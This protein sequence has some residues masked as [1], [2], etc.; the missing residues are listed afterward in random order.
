MANDLVVAV[1]ANIQQLERQMKAAAQVSEK[2]AADIENRFRKV[3]PSIS[4]SALTGAL[5]GFAAAFTVD[6]IIRGLADANAELV[7]VGETA[8]RV[9]LDLQRF[10]E[11]QFAGR[12]NGL[13]GK[14]F[15]TGLE[16][17]AEKLNEARQKENELSQ[18][19]AD[20]NVKLKDRKGEVI[21]VNEALGKAAELV[22][23]AATEFDK[24]KIAEAVGLTKEW[25]P[26]LEQGAEAINRQASAARDAGAVI[27]SDIIRKAKDF[28]RDWAGAI[29]RW[30]TLFKANAGAIIAV[31]DTII[32]KASELFSGLDRY[33]KGLQAKADLEANGPA[34]A[35]RSTLDYARNEFSKV[36][37]PLPRAL[38]ERLDQLN[39]FDREAARAKG[40]EAA[41]PLEV[42]VRR[43]RPTDTSSLFGGKGG[44]GGGGKS[45][46]E[47]AQARLE[48]YIETLMR[49]NSVLDAEIATFGKSNAERRAAVE[50][51]KAQVDLAKL[52]ETE[53]QKI[54]AS[55]TREI[56]LSE[57]K[58]TQLESLKTAQ[59]GLVDAQKFFGEA[60]VDALE[61][62][63]FNGAKAEDVVKNLAKALAK[64][65]LQA[66]LLGT[67]PFAG[68][69][70]T[71]GTNGNAGGIF[72]MMPSL[73]GRATGGPVNAGQPYRVG[74]RGPE[75]FVPT[76]PGK[77]VPASRGGGMR[78]VINN[79]AA[80]QVAATAQQQPNG[81]LSVMIAAVEG[82]IARNVVR[83]AGA[84]APALGAVRSGRQLRG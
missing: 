48:R 63:I 61:D 65:A 75:T 37:Q 4:T 31:I 13:S 10:Q 19:F 6:R 62:L 70:G 64:A 9:G 58:R 55:L 73:F 67:G 56:E 29:D 27:D 77:I 79:N 45:E 83:G 54:I 11:L 21:G 82:Q 8:K 16:G 32:G 28:E 33:S 66:A 47:Q 34:G 12:Q 46:D 22:R 24:I 42:T 50:L 69:F 39:E 51:A 36:G 1:G 15:G 84:L 53:R 26:L 43:N 59:K 71:A 38:Q 5:K 78:V 30:A 40:R 7:R 35:S 18:L 81:D 3:N 2:A 57:Q 72:G 52:D 80:G 41:S 25:V 60:A 49:Q 14:D 44:G 76:V 17:L 23:N 74:E 20:N 68:I